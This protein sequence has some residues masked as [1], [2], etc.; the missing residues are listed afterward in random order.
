VEHENTILLGD[1]LER[2]NELPDAS[3]DLIATDPPYGYSFLGKDWD[4]AVPSVPLWQEC[5]RVLKPGGFAFVMSAPRQDVLSQMIVRIGEAG[6][7]TD[8]TSIYWTYA[9]GFP[10]A[11]NI[12]KMVDKRN[13]RIVDPAVKTYLNERR[14]AKGLSLNQIN[15]LLGT[16]TTGGGVASAIM[17]DKPFNELPTVAVYA[18][19]KTIL[20][21]DDRFDELIER[22]EAEREVIATRRQTVGGNGIYGEYADVADITLPSTDAAKALN[23]SYGGFQPKPA[24]EVI[25]VAMKPLSEK[26]FVN[27]ALKNGKGI[28][29]LDDARIPT[30]EKVRVNTAGGL[31]YASNTDIKSGTGTAYTDEGRFPAN[32]LSRTL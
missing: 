3:V 11:M 32:L 20:E 19:L 16:A 1:C 6:F 17:G 31:G 13:G 14:R 2:L 21:L 9:S 12:G 27:Q 29:W 24:V 7:D 8:F 15:E 30:L 4:K 10:K 25:I 5:L 18:Q 28:T 23:G 22:Q 26:T